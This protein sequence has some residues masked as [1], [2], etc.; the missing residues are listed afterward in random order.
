MTNC[1]KGEECVATTNAQCT[2]ETARWAR[3]INLA[4]V[5]EG[6]EEEEE[7]EEE[8]REGESRASS[9]RG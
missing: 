1:P 6:K 7:E 4:K 5:E 3:I 9:G 2:I 8:E